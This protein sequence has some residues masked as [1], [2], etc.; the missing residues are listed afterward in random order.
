MQNLC[1]KILNKHMETIAV[2]KGV[3]EANLVFSGEYQ[4]GDT[5]I[6]EIAEG[7]HYVWLQLDDAMGKSLVFLTG[8]ISYRIPFGEKRMNLSPKAFS[9]KK[10]LLSAKC[11]RDFEIETYRNLAFNVCDQHDVTDLFPHAT[12]NVETR[13]ETVFAAQNAIDGVTVSNCHGEWPYGS[14]GINRQKDACIRIDFGRTIM[15][16]RLV[17]YLRSDFPH[18][19]WWEQVSFKFS[20]ESTLDMKL[21]KKE[22][23]QETVFDEKHIDWLEMYNMKMSGEPS[24]FPALTQIEV[25]GKDLVAVSET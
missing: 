2:S 15:V 23:P 22:G 14:W 25:Y 10:H 21:A 3:N 4:E 13:G 18:D 9:G 16:D 5:V 24:P 17:L 12:A 7:V 20:D 1:L 19:N 11:A 6:L 8:N